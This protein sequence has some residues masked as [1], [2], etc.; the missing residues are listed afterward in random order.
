MTQNLQDLPESVFKQAPGVSDD[1]ESVGNMQW[2]KPCSHVLW[3]PRCPRRAEVWAGS[4]KFGVRTWNQAGVRCR[5]RLGSLLGNQGKGEALISRKWSESWARYAVPLV[6]GNGGDKG[7]EKED[8]YIKAPGDGL[9]FP[10]LNPH[11][12]TALHTLPLGTTYTLRSLGRTF[13]FSNDVSLGPKL[14]SKVVSLPRTGPTGVL[15]GH[16]CARRC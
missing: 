16:Q 2:M 4:L 12:S 15:R 13:W 3:V 6:G 11:L 7:S 9:A 14:P 8:T 5:Q 1:S 10:S